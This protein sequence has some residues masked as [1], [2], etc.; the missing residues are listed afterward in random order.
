[1][2]DE[3]HPIGLTPYGTYLAASEEIDRDL[4]HFLTSQHTSWGEVR[5]A[6]EKLGQ[7]EKFLKG[8]TKEGFAPTDAVLRELWVLL[9]SHHHL[10]LEAA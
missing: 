9:F 3:L 4:E 10:F 5:F 2:E 1:L 8:Y 7:I 6:S